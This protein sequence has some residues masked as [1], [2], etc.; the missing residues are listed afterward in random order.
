[1]A[2]QHSSLAVCEFRTA[3][4]ERCRQGYDRC[5]LQDVVATE[6]DR[7]YN[8]RELKIVYFRVITQEFCMVGGYTENFTLKQQ[9]CQNWG[10]GALARDNVVYIY[11]Q[12]DF[13]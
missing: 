1:M 13:I 7:S 11:T 3:S 9:N 12:Q 6:T 4:E 8:L 2:S 5:V 10:G